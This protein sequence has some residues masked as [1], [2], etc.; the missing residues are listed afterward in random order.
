MQR[1]HRI[2]VVPNLR[3]LHL[4]GHP[5]LV[6]LAWFS[7]VSCSRRAHSSPSSSPS[8]HFEPRPT[9]ASAVTFACASVKNTRVLQFHSWLLFSTARN[10]SISL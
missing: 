8:V 2:L 3:K 6:T 9:A 7:H 10:T 5:S 4:H 1:L